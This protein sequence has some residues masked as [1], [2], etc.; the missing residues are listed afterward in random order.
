MAFPS[1][2]HICTEKENRLRGG[3][4][5]QQHRIN[6]HSHGGQKEHQTDRQKRGNGQKEGKMSRW[7]EGGV[8]WETAQAE[9]REGGRER[10]LGGRLGGR[11]GRG[12]LWG[13]RPLQACQD[14]SLRCHAEDEKFA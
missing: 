14:G 11:L 10:E 13:E 2:L 12:R 5:R 3:S 9:T 6:H 7:E 4:G 8:G 1:R